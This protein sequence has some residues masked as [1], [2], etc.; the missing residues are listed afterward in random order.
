MVTHNIWCQKWLDWK[1][2]W[3]LIVIPPYYENGTNDG[4][5]DGMSAG[6]DNCH[7]GKGGLSSRKM[8]ASQEWMVAKMDA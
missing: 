4:T 8:N 3:I 6:Q 2:H 7:A 1:L 5:G